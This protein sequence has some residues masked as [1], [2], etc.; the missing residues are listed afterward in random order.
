M[1]VNSGLYIWN[2][3]QKILP[4][5]N[6]LLHGGCSKQMKVAEIKVKVKWRCGFWFISNAISDPILLLPEISP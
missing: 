4:V 5:A 1:Y 3:G 2:C 6:Q